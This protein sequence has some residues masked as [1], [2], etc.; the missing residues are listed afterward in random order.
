MLDESGWMALT[1]ARIQ[2]KVSVPLALPSVVTQRSV[3]HSTFDVTWHVLRM[4]PFQLQDAVLYEDV[5]QVADKLRQSGR[6]WTEVP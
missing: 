2:R 1:K 4:D 5:R 3:S 6:G